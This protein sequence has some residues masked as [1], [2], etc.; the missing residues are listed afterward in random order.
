MVVGHFL[1]AYIVPIMMGQQASSSLL[2]LPK[3]NK[4]YCSNHI[5]VFYHIIMM[6]SH[7]CRLVYH[8]D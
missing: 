3:K 7:K 4:Q 6:A 8:K 2:Y 5:H 1:P